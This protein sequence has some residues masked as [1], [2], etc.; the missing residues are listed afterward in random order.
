MRPSF[1][2]LRRKPRRGGLFIDGPLI[3]SLFFGSAAAVTLNHSVSLLAAPPKNK[4]NRMA[5]GS[6]NRPPLRGPLRGF[7]EAA[8]LDR[9]RL[10]TNDGIQVF[11]KS[12]DAQRKNLWVKIRPGVASLDTPPTLGGTS[13]RG[14]PRP[15]EMDSNTEDEAVRTRLAS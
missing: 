9:V 6:I 5:R 7:G 2:R 12:R 8:L 13:G 15:R 4:A 14:R 1:V 11:R 3:Y 10:G